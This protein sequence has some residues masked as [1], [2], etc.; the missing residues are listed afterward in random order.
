MGKILTRMGDGSPVELSPAELRQDLE[1]GS[2]DAAD[3]GNVPGLDEEDFRYLEELFTRRDRFVGVDVGNE[4]VLTYDGA[5]LKFKRHCLF[6]ERLH[7][8][9]LYEKMFG[10]DTVELGHV[11]YSYKPVKPIV[12]YEQGTLEMGLLTTHSPLIY[13]AMPNLG[14]YTKPDG[15]CPNPMELLPQGKI[16]EARAA[17]ADMVEEA[18]RDIVFVVGSMYESGADGFNLD[19]VGASGDADVLASFL[20]LEKLRAKYPDIAVEVG[21]AGEFILGMHGELEYDGKRLAGLYP[22]QQ[23][24]LA[25]KA[26]AVIFG[27]VVNTNTD[28]TIPWNLAR[29][30][31][32]TR[33][34]S[35]ASNIP[36][37][38][39]MGMGVGA[40]PVT[41]FPP[42]DVLSRASKA[43]VE[44]CGLDGL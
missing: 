5:A 17:Y 38:A 1:D 36:V 10:A 26:G 25:E 37:H 40:V 9:T 7:V 16:K 30:V 6:E 3:R 39:N 18:V 32:F 8:L 19:T 12:N 11:D 22:H 33:A 15:P 31:V 20:A 27:P 14:L 34:C 4:V 28:Q 35:K 44:L 2:A 41:D 29:T 42:V 13:G 21:M 23:V 24:P 43:L